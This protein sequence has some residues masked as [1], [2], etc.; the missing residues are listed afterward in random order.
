MANLQNSPIERIIFLGGNGH[1]AARL[2]AARMVL[3]ALADAG[4]AAPI[5]LEELAYPGF[6]GRPRALSAEDFL[7]TAA[8]RLE[9]MLGEAPTPMI[10]ATGIGGLIALCL[11]ARSSHIAAVP[12]LL[13]AP[14]LWGLERRLFPRLMRRLPVRALLPT[15]FG[16]T[17]FQNRFVRRYFTQ[18]LGSELRNAFFGGY[19]ECATLPD[20]F[21]WFTPH[22][23]RGLESIFRAQPERL[24]NVQ[25]WW[26]GRDRVV[27]Q[28]ELRDTQQALCVEWPVKL[29]P[30]WGHYPMIDAPEEWARELSHAVRQGKACASQAELGS[31]P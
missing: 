17:A 21:L 3:A 7:A 12:L 9:G 8:A 10:Y 25:V 31:H 11:R 22:M 26:G 30:E 18:P 20:L 13:Q 28:T 1:C 23:L 15:L 5:S 14:V 2:G 16:L 27:D 19:R 6:E 24:R 4:G 29:F